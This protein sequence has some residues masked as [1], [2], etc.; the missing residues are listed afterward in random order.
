MLVKHHIDFG[1]IAW[2]Q[3]Q[4]AAAYSNMAQL[5]PAIMELMNG[6]GLHYWAMRG[7]PAPFLAAITNAINPYVGEQHCLAQ[8]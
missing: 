4:V 3:E 8:I 2:L 7:L 6:L 5:L 1:G